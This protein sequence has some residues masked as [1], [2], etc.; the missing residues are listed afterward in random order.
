MGSSASLELIPLHPAR[1]LHW[2]PFGDSVL[3]FHLSE[4][5][6]VPKQLSN[7]GNHRTSQRM[8][9]L[10]LKCRW[11]LP[12]FHFTT[13]HS[14]LYFFPEWKAGNHSFCHQS[15][16]PT[17]LESHVV[18]VAYAFSFTWVCWKAARVG[19]PTWKCFSGFI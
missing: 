13:L 6:K 5:T 17:L 10:T 3:F 18:V 19:I 12:S 15:F 16:P 11:A 1:G 7:L 2:L 8:F 4:D 9:L 14:K